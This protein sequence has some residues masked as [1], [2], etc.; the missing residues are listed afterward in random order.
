MNKKQIKELIPAKKG[1]G[2]KVDGLGPDDIK[3]L[4]TAIRKVWS[5]SYAR[6]LCVARAT[7]KD[8]FPRCE[9]CMKKVPKIF[10]D[11]IVPCGELDGGYINRM[12]IS[13][14]GLQA[15]CAKCHR[16]KTNEE[17]AFR[18]ALKKSF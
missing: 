10:P 5:W 1:K 17:N 6:R 11:H 16:L 2:V 3:K 18:R 8:G 15:L 12:F 4:R 9:K 13:S 14:K 7:G